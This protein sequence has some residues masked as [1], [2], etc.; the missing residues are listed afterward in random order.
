LTL[1]RYRPRATAARLYASASPMQ[2]FGQRLRGQHCQ[3]PD[4][5]TVMS[6]VGIRPTAE[7][8]TVP[9][10]PSG[11]YPAVI[12]GHQRARRFS[13]IPSARNKSR[14]RPRAATMRS[15]MPRRVSSSCHWCGMCEPAKSTCGDAERSESDLR[16][17]R[18]CGALMERFIRK[19]YLALMSRS[20]SMCEHN[21]STTCPECAG[22]SG[23]PS[24]RI[25]RLVQHVSSASGC[26]QRFAVPERSAHLAAHTAVSIKP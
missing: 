12:Q 15:L 16:S 4:R 25:D 8:G 21:A 6:T 11:G 19:V 5:F 9:P 22:R 20:G 23:Y 13:P 1:F 3:H 2:R 26:F 14:T 10:L 24:D 7:G 18:V 17:S